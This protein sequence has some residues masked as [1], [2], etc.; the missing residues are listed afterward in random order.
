MRLES[1]LETLRKSNETKAVFKAVCIPEELTPSNVDAISSL[2]D[3]AVHLLLV[4]LKT[5]ILFLKHCIHSRKDMILSGLDIPAVWSLLKVVFCM[6]DFFTYFLFRRLK[7]K[8]T[9]ASDFRWL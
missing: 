5:F 9:H 3:Y 6:T 7:I 2:N 8:K 4:C 1:E